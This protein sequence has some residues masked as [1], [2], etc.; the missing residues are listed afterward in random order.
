MG[1][2]GLLQC[3]CYYIYYVYSNSGVAMA[4]FIGASPSA[5]CTSHLEPGPLPAQSQLAF[6]HLPPSMGTVGGVLD[7][8]NGQGALPDGGTTFLG[9][10]KV[11]FWFLIQ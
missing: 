8:K 5:L 1:R 6:P 11:N 4:V 10:R 9:C 3:V 7:F 2:P